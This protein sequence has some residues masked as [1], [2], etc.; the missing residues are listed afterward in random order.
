[1]CLN[2]IADICVISSYLIIRVLDAIDQKKIL[3]AIYQK[4]YY[5]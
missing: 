4:W 3:V 1:M 5:L 2:K